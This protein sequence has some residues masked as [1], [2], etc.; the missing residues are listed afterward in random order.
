MKLRWFKQDST[1]KKA[2]SYID[3]V[4]GWGFV[5]CIAGSTW[6]SK[7]LQRDQQNKR[8][9]KGLSFSTSCWS[10]TKQIS[11][12]TLGL[13]LCWKLEAR[14]IF[15]LASFLYPNCHTSLAWILCVPVKSFHCNC[16]YLIVN[17]FIHY[18][19]EATECEVIFFHYPAVKFSNRYFWNSGDFECGRTNSVGVAYATPGK[20]PVSVELHQVWIWHEN[21]LQT[22]S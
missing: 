1:Q 7:T 12:M 5:L 9:C 13:L 6:F 20:L 3:P 15:Q 21:L 19:N 17:E 10:S 16:N 4:V 14:L 11:A 8:W 22:Q 2:F 18:W